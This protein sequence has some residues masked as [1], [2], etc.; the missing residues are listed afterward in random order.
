[1]VKMLRIGALLVN[2][3]QILYIAPIVER[4]FF[5]GVEY[6]RVEVIMNGGEPIKIRC[7]DQQDVDNYMNIFNFQIGK[8]YGRENPSSDVS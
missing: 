4:N 3:E 5:T 6:Y 1:M 7:K 8:A 2:I